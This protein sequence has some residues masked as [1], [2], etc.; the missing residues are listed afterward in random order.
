MYLLDLSSECATCKWTSILNS[1]IQTWNWN[2]QRTL[3]FSIRR[4]TKS[5]FC[6]SLSLF[7]WLIAQEYNILQLSNCSEV[8]LTS[9]DEVWRR[10]ARVLWNAYEPLSVCRHMRRTE[11]AESLKELEKRF[12]CPPRVIEGP[13]G[14]SGGRAGRLSSILRGYQRALTKHYVIMYANS[15]M[16]IRAG[17]RSRPSLGSAKT[18]HLWTRC[19]P[20]RPRATIYISWSVFVH[21]KL[22]ACH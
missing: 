5:T 22:N 8:V 11:D 2:F 15:I 17:R 4:F 20:A 1:L 12:E 18:H 13:W 16:L 21:I 6:L 19:S 9:E 7:L 10:R 3:V 14:C